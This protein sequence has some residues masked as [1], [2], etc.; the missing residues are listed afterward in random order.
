MSQRV[1]TTT[2]NLLR[3]HHDSALAAIFRPPVSCPRDPRDGSYFLDRNGQVFGIILDYLRTGV[4]TVPRDPVG[5]SQLRREV[6]YFG[7][8]VAMQLPQIAPM[9]WQSAPKRYR[10]ARIVVDELEKQVEWE[11]GALP[12][13]LSRRTVLEIISF[14]GAQGYRVASEYV[15]RGS[16]GYTSVWLVKE[17]VYPGADVPLE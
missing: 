9:L 2:L 15:S 11:E 7:L 6:V 17:E 10:H 8:P 5:Y 3:Q 16:S 14:F 13:D 12:Q 4:L 1:F